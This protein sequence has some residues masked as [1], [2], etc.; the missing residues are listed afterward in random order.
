[1]PAIARE[2]DSWS[3]LDWVESGDG[4]GVAIPRRPRTLRQNLRL[5][6]TPT[7]SAFDDVVVR[8]EFVNRGRTNEPIQV[9]WKIVVSAVCGVLLLL[10]GV[11]GITLV[12]FGL[13]STPF[14][15]MCY[16]IPIG[17][18]T[19]YMALKAATPTL[20]SV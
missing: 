10:L 3:R 2:N 6:E 18:W 16:F 20:G 19:V 11:L 12:A 13:K 15:V 1:M 8:S 14:I 5:A 7:E 17:V 4:F 9:S